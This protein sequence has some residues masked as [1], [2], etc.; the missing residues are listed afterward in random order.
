MYF[1]FYICRGLKLPALTKAVKATSARL[2]SASRKKDGGEKGMVVQKPEEDH[3]PLIICTQGPVE[4]TPEKLVVNIET[5][6]FQPASGQQLQTAQR[7]KPFKPGNLRWWDGGRGRTKYQPK[8]SSLDADNILEKGDDD[9]IVDEQTTYNEWLAAQ[10]LVGLSEDQPSKGDIRKLHDKGD[11]L[12]SDYDK[13]IEAETEVDS[14][15]N[16]KDDSNNEKV[17]KDKGTPVKCKEIMKRQTKMK[18]TKARQIIL[19]RNKKGNVKVHSVPQK[20]QKQSEGR[21]ESDLSE[22]SSLH[23]Q[24]ESMI[25]QGK[26]D[27]DSICKINTLKSILAML[28]KPEDKCKT[29]EKHET[30]RKSRETDQHLKHDE[31]INSDLSKGEEISSDLKADEQLKQDEKLS[32]DLTQDEKLSGECIKTENVI[33]KIQVDEPYSS[34]ESTNDLTVKEKSDMLNENVELENQKEKVSIIETASCIETM[35]QLNEALHDTDTDDT[36]CADKLVIDDNQVLDYSLPVTDTGQDIEKVVTDV[37]GDLLD[38]VLAKVEE[39][40]EELSCTPP[41]SQIP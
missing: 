22:M 8:D 32:S 17:E 3:K 23:M 7:G 36:S 15:E 39:D 31:Q 40:G 4:G 19:K 33:L 5:L 14:K 29:D 6:S 21:D 26:T 35:A 18:L 16:V 11:K 28:D 13:K 38:N 2:R 34:D 25:K 30:K 9:I 12:E 27:A 10:G 37:V 1:I 24:V 20:E 41:C